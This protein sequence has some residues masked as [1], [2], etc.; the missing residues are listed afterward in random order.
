MDCKEIFT[1]AIE[2]H[3]EYLKNIQKNI[4]GSGDYC[5]T[6]HHL[7]PLGKWLYGE[8]KTDVKACG[9][10]AEKIFEQ[11]FEPHEQFH[12]VSDTS[13]KAFDENNRTL[14]KESLTEMLYLSGKLMKLLM[15]LNEIAN[16]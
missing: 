4:D 2:S 1:H 9:R 12:H 3:L 5:G 13:I 8:G 16:K 15:E 14:A 10:K 11:L 7:C 6:D